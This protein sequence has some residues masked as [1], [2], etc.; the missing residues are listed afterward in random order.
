M[1]ASD[2]GLCRG[3][4]TGGKG[5]R[6]G[7]FSS[8]IFWLHRGRYA[9][10]EAFVKFVTAFTPYF[11]KIFF[12]DSVAREHHDAPYFLDSDKI[13][14]CAIPPYNLCLHTSWVRGLAT[15]PRIF[16]IAKT[17][18]PCWDLAWIHGPHPVGLLLAHL[19]QK[20]GKPFFL[21]VRQNLPVYVSHRS[22]GLKRYLA[23]AIAG[24]LESCFQRLSRDALTFA[25]GREMFHIYQ[26]CGGR[27]EEVYVSLIGCRDIQKGNREGSKTRLSP[28]R[29]LSV[30]RL[31]PEKGMVFL[32]EALRR[33]IQE[34]G[35]N[36]VLDIVGTGNLEETLQRKV[37]EQGLS[38]RVRF[39][40]YVPHGE[41]LLSL[42]RN[43]HIYVLP[44]LTEGSPQTIFEAMASGVPV[45]ASRVG[46]IPYLIQ[47]GENGLLVNPRSAQEICNGVGRLIDNRDLRVKLVRAGLET[48]R[49]HT[50]EAER[51]KIMGVVAEHFG[52]RG[53]RRA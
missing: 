47:D 50:L 37:E 3:L 49:Q 41:E 40:G 8:Q 14:V 51:D 42:Y 26:K 25:V 33:L 22:Q 9:T 34:C 53:L 4:I 23:M 29:I 21:F 35:R 6:L 10:D 43:S 16:Q 45:V 44:S 15:L 2:K 13:Q 17:N 31:D 52:L 46:G 1:T 28:I 11:D 39:H 12:F 48:V 27:V 18:I 30:G 5:L 7:V 36:V 38:G 24:A 19:C 32:I 20:S